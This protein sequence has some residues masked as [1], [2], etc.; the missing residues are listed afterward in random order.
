MGGIAFLFPGQGAQFVGMGRDVSERF[1]AARRVFQEADDVLGY[2]ISHLCFN[3]PDGD[4]KRT[5]HT[6]PA[7]FVTS[8]AC[9]AAALE[10][11]VINRQDG[12]DLVAGHSLGEYTALVAAG[13]VSYPDALRLVQLRAQLMEQVG[14]QHPGTMAAVLGLDANVLLDVCSETGVEI[15]NI[16]ALDQIVI[17]GSV[18]GITAAMDLA[19]TRGARRVVLLEVGGAFHSKLMGPASDGMDAAVKSVEFADPSPPVVANSTATPITKRDEI[20]AELVRQLCSPVRWV[21]T[22]FLMRAR[23]I[24][25]YLEFGP[26]NV[27]TGLVKR[28][29]KESVTRNYGDAASIL[30]SRA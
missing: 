4:L 18:E 16:N 1:A 22:I 17:S 5:L 6:Q 30:G 13:A 14:V 15:A 26:G 24:Q 21:E 25:E 28:L 7:V 11:G 29:H 10:A 27:L 12:P 3:G 8:Y 23:G 20:G 2:S 19:K 9:L